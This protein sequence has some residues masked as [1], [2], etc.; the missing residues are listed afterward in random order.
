[1]TNRDPPCDERVE[2]VLHTVLRPPG[3]KLS[4]LTPLIPQPSLGLAQDHVLLLLPLALLHA[5]I[6]VI[7][8]PL[9]ALLASPP[10]DML[11]Q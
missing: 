6:Q 11:R 1:M 2:A 7:Q 8:P 3:Q 9:P 5:L 10:R 4:N